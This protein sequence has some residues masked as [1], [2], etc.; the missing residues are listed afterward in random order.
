MHDKGDS[1]AV[2]QLREEIVKRAG[3]CPIRFAD[4]LVAIHPLASMHTSAYEKRRP[5]LEA[6]ESA[7]ARYEPFLSKAFYLRTHILVR[8]ERCR[9][10]DSLGNLEDAIDCYEEVWE[11]LPDGDHPDARLLLALR[12]ALPYSIASLHHATGNY[13]SAQD[14]LEIIRQYLYVGHHTYPG[15]YYNL[16]GKINRSLGNYR[17]AE[18]DFLSARQAFEIDSV[19]WASNHFIENFVDLSDLYLTTSSAQKALPPLEEAAAQGIDSLFSRRYLHHQLAKTYLALDSLP[20]A[21]EQSRKGLLVTR[22]LND[23]SYFWTGRMLSLIG[24]TLGRQGQWAEAIDTL[25]VAM[26]HLANF[27]PDGDAWDKNPNPDSSNTKLDLLKAL[28]LKART[29]EAYYRSSA[30]APIPLLEASLQTSLRAIDLIR[31]LRSAYPDDEVREYLSQRSFPIFEDALRVAF[32]LC[33]LTGADEHLEAAFSIMESGKA[34]SLLENL[35]EL[36]ARS[37]AGIPPKVLQEENRLHYKMTTLERSLREITDAEKSRTLRNTLFSARQDYQ[38]LIELFQDAYPEYY[39]LKFQTTP[40]TIRELSRRLAD[41]ETLI[42][43]FYGEKRLYAIAIDR[44]GVRRQVHPVDSTFNRSIDEFIELTGSS[45]RMTKAADI[46]R[47]LAS[48]SLL[49]QRLLAPLELQTRKLTI[50]PDG[51]LHYLPFNALPTSAG[52]RYSSARKLPYLLRDHLIQRNFSA[53]VR[54]QQQATPSQNT[55]GRE[56]LLVVSPSAFPEQSSLSLDPA[57]LADRFGEQVRI[58]RDVSKEA[59]RRLLDEGYQYIFIFSHASAREADPF[60]ELFQER[61]YLRELYATPVNAHLVLLGA[62]ETGLGKQLRGEGVLSLARGFAYQNVPNTIMTLWK[63]QDGP[64]LEI[65]LDFLQR[66]LVKGV[67]MPE[68]LNQ[69]QQYYIDYGDGYGQP[70]QWAGFVG[71]GSY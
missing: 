8:Y 37:F 44:S 29:L 39:R 13:R 36:K 64:A 1:E 25:Q 61:F 19:G 65:S 11:L 48:G 23:S 43:Y 15:V 31:V 28:V 55:I 22:R 18:E 60:L 35:V 68:A 3:Q 20:H 6:G 26:T 62:C 47:Y 38:E 41:D 56:P 9:Y 30:P 66:H 54:L 58:E 32:D 51:R 71:V 16:K 49:Y 40:I 4:Y 10:D 52:A 33:D 42:E 57:D 70:F 24:E 67:S 63:V 46:E 17:Q 14:W 53:S 2:L 7:L 21:L 59:F 5:H 27:S 69:A 45:R 34:L 50:I 12:N